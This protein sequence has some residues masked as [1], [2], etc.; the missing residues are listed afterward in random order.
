MSKFFP[1][2]VFFIGGI[3]L[4]TTAH[5]DNRTAQAL[6]PTKSKILFGIEGSP[7]ALSGGFRT[8]SG[9]LERGKSFGDS[10]IAFAVDLSKVRLDPAFGGLDMVSF[11]P[12]FQKIPD[13]VGRFRSSKITAQQG[14]QF[15]VTGIWERGKKQQQVQFPVIVTASTAQETRLKARIIQRIEKWDN[16]IPLPIK[17][18]QSEG[19]IYGELL[20]RAR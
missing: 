18:G 3:L 17:P 19:N 16:S 14:N 5:A 9:S 13:P 4:S 12:L 7:L 11:E 15:Q 1:I 10:V 6:I 20:F 2:I 8:Y